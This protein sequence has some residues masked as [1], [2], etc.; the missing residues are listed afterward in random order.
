MRSP[1][2][3]QPGSAMTRCGVNGLTSMSGDRFHH[4]LTLMKL[5]LDRMANIAKLPRMIKGKRESVVRNLICA[6]GGRQTRPRI[7]AL[8]ALLK[9]DRTVSHADLHRRLPDIDRVSLYRALDW[10][11][12]HH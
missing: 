5:G 2:E 11:T 10:L 3:Q 4:F 12:A 7:V 6:A 8:K 9:A 1:G